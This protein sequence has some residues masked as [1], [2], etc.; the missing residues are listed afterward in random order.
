[1]TRSLSWSVKPITTPSTRVSLRIVASVVTSDARCA[2]IAGLMDFMPDASQAQLEHRDLAPVAQIVEL[3]VDRHR[4]GIE[5]AR[6]VELE[7]GGDDDVGRRRHAEGDDA[8]GRI[9]G[10]AGQLFDRVLVDLDGSGDRLPDIP[11]LGDAAGRVRLNELEGGRGTVADADRLRR[12]LVVRPVLEAE[13][14]RL[15]L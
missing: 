6:H 3:Q 13:A 4:V 7:V 1:M 11:G 5:A 10:P 2:S 9:E 15:A 8:G 14:V 12:R